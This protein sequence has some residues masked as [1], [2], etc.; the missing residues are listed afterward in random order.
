MA[1]DR[2][3]VES[4]QRNLR[5]GIYE[6]GLLSPRHENGLRQFQDLVRKAE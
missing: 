4:V 5:A 2:R 1:Q 3:I 6:S